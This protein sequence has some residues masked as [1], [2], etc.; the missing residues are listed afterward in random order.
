MLFE[1]RARW[2]FGTGQRLGDLRRLVRQYGY[3][4]SMVFPTGTYAKGGPYG[5]DVN[6]PIPFEEHEN[7]ALSGLEGQPL[8]L[9]R[10]A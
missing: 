6:F 10:N 1:E 5:T 7:Q 4:Q 8:C 9:D 2:L 3:D